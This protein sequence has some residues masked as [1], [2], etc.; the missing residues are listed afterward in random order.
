MHPLYHQQVRWSGTAAG[1]AS[2]ASESDRAQVKEER[3]K[4]PPADE[5]D[6]ARASTSSRFRN[7]GYATNDAETP[8]GKLRDYDPW[9]VLGLTPGA[10]AHAIR[11]KYHELLTECHPEYVKRGAEPDIVRLNQINKAYEII[12]RSPTLD[13]RY[14]NLVSDAQ[15]IYYRFLP[16]WMAKN[17]DEAPRYISWV[18]WRVPTALQL[19]MLAFGCYALGRFYVAFP[20]PTTVLLTCIAM[21]YLL[22]TMSAPFAFSILFLH[23]MFSGKTYSMSWLLSPRG[24]L[25]DGLS[26]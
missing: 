16:E 23:A 21:D 26:Y 8:E 9:A 11:L 19:F 7:D 14:R 1:T 24:F 3:S 6:A 2:F 22:H 17:V 20:A 4:A 18:R 15:R 12:T 10:S 13:K 25:Q 5:E